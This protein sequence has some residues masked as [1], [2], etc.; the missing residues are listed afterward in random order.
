MGGWV[1]RGQAGRKRPVLARVFHAD[2]LPDRPLKELVGGPA[3]QR[4]DDEF[5]GKGG[6]SQHRCQD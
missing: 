2:P 3:H 6:G 4:D 5:A 1:A